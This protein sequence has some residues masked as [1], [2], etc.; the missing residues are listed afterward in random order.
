M[1]E[2]LRATTSPVNRLLQGFFE[3][4]CISGNTT[5]TNTTLRPRHTLTAT[6]IATP[7]PYH[8]R[9]APYAL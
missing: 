1:H 5:P 4:S 9:A 6:L 7:T 2:Y 8:P 3:F